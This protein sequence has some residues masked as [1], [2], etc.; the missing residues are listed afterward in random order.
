VPFAAADPALAR[1]A[2]P[3]TDDTRPLLFV[4]VD[5]EE[6]FDWKAPSPYSRA[7]VHVTAMREI[8][9]G[10]ALFDRYGVK[11]TYVVDYPVA[12]QRDGYAPLK[13]ILDRG[14]CT[15]GAHLHPWVNPP[16]T[17]EVCERN[18]FASNLGPELESA[19]L[20]VLCDAIGE[21]FGVKPLMYKAGRYGIGRA[22]TAI[23]ESFGFE[24]DNSVN[25][26]MDF[27]NQHG[28]NFEA[29]DARPFLFGQSRWLLELPCTRGFT[30]IAGGVGPVLHRMAS[31]KSLEPLRL[32]GI[33]ARLGVTNKIMLSPEGS[34]AEEMKQMA[35]S[36][37][38]RGVR[39][40]TMTFHSPSL[41]PGH[42]PYVRSESDLRVLLSATDSFLDFFFTKLGGE[43]STP[44]VYRR[45]ALA[46]LGLDA[47]S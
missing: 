38:A 44:S 3:Q 37:V 43:A 12:T 40:L 10:Q 4:V 36:L 22:T 45:T 6:E 1:T 41:A 7:N 9:R 13:A 17:E 47:T 35:A 19:K 42:T 2:I 33:L 34:T 32:V 30:G 46:R 25:P 29:Y 24:S 20:R 26:H 14:G 18:S 23:L 39:T 5:T 15:V 31:A 16:Y 8:E 21:S 27:S 11:P 28:P